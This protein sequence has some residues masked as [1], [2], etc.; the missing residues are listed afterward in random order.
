MIMDYDSEF[1]ADQGIQGDGP[2]DNQARV[3]PINN[4]TVEN[5]LAYI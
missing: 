3:I 5:E 1:F 4:Y 2:D